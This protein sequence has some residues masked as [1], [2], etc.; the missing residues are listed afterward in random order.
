MK[1]MKPDQFFRPYT[2]VNSKWFNA[3]GVRLENG[4]FLAYT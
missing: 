4:K 1:R 3:L 2:K